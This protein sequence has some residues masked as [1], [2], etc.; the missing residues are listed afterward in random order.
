M[1]VAPQQSG[2]ETRPKTN[3]VHSAGK[4]TTS[5]LCVRIYTSLILQ[6]VLGRWYLYDIDTMI[7]YRKGLLKFGVRTLNAHTLNH[8]GLGSK[9]PLKPLKVQSCDRERG[10]FRD[11][12]PPPTSVVEPLHSRRCPLQSIASPLT[13][14]QGWPSV[15]TR[16]DVGFLRR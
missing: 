4:L 11:R 16:R 5:V 13:T 15:V 10:I 14:V 6:S 7:C 9:I 12:P 2:A 1:Y 8:S 3:L